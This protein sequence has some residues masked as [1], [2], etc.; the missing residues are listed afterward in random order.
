MIT[1][2]TSYSNEKLKFIKSLSQHKNREKYGKFTVEGLRSVCDALACGRAEMI[3]ATDDMLS[4]IQTDIPIYRVSDGIFGKI[5]ETSSPQGILAVVG[6][7]RKEFKIKDGGAYVYCDCIRDPGN[8]GTIIRTAD[9]AGFDAVLLSPETV[10]C[11]NQKVVRASMGSFFRM[12]IYENIDVS[13]LDGVK[14]FGGIL[15]GDTIDYRNTDYGGTIAIA[16]GNEANGI[17]ENVKNRCIP[18]KIPIYGGAESLN[19]AVAAALMIYEAA[20]CRHERKG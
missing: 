16:V 17:S 9:S 14:L 7:E 5:S 2:I 3:F 12:D 15:S 1:D 10:D 11:Y 13:M 20:N 4:N 19:A 6:T 8:L 18:I